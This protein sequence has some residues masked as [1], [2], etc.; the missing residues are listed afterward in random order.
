MTVFQDVPG[1]FIDLF[2][3]EDMLDQPKTHLS[4]NQICHVKGK[5][6]RSRMKLN[7]QIWLSLGLEVGVLCTFLCSKKSAFDNNHGLSNSFE[8]HDESLCFYCV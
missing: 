6:A 7:S 4:F 1:L 3:L 5:C 2:V 8:E